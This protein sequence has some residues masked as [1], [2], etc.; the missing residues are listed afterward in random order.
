MI[1]LPF[2]SSNQTDISERILA[3]RVALLNQNL[4][5]SIPASFICCTV[6]A[7]SLY[8]IVD[9]TLIIAWFCANIIIFVIRFGFS[10]WYKLRPEKTDLHLKLFVLGSSLSA[11]M[12]GIAGTILMPPSEHLYQT[13]IIVIIAGITSGSMITL[14][15]SP[16]ASFLYVLIGVLPLNIWLYAQGIQ[17][18][19]LIGVTVSGYIVFML[20]TAKRGFQLLMTAYH[21]Q[22]QNLTMNEDLET[23]NQL[24][25][26]E[27][28]KH[29]ESEKS[30]AELAAIVEFSHD[31]IIGL[32]VNG[33][34]QTWNKG[35][36]ILYG[37]TAQEIH[38]QPM[39]FLSPESQRD[40]VD[41]LL[42]KTVNDI[43]I[44]H[45]ELERRHKLGHLIPVSVTLSPIKKATGSAGNTSQIIGMSS[46]DR[47]ISERREIDKLKNEFISVVS[48]E[49][50]TPLTSIKGSLALILAKDKG[51]LT[52]QMHQLLQISS[53]NCERL[54]R[55]INDILDVEKMESGKLDFKMIKINLRNLI[56]HSVEETQAFADKYNVQL[57]VNTPIEVYIHGDYDRLIQVMT[58]LISNAVKFSP[59]QGT[60]S[61]EIKM[62]GHQVMVS[63]TD[64]GPGIPTEFQDRIFNKFAQADSAST[65]SK[66]GTGLGLSIV[67]AILDK[68]N[69]K[70]SFTTEEGKGTTFYFCL[71]VVGENHVGDTKNQKSAPYRTE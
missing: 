61:I 25:K 11:L 15:A 70:I 32:D 30:L 42:E 52:Q 18:Y 65:R 59:P 26:I 47:D 60:V 21:L 69:S 56:E 10:W 49:L 4:R 17:S 8:G 3:D 40:I 27:V 39:H 6:L 33:H 2:F 14:Q 63:V 5:T 58:N 22:Y 43:S 68:H 41:S 7:V 46:M 20:I 16:L 34:I 62:Q 28:L 13:V 45:V 19:V 24:L 71:A 35:A 29:K 9:K 67:K 31:A 36:E 44:Q 48:H 54:I 53:N 50:R 64:E 51:Q 38:G 57:K 37:Y 55:L 23:A 1:K 12:L 66:G